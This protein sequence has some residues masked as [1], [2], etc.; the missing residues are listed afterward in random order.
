MI[1]VLL[2]HCC[3]RA[4]GLAGFSE[5]LGDRQHLIDWNRTLREHLLA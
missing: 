3:G 1:A 4:C 5:L 2:D